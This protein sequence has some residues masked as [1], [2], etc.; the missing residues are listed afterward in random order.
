M[1][2]KLLPVPVAAMLLL[3]A[4]VT[5]NIYFPAA[6]AEKAADQIIKDIQSPAP[7]EAP[8][9]NNSRWQGNN[10][11]RWLDAALNLLVTPAHAGN[12]DLSLDS[13]EISRLR[14]AMKRR[15]ASL[16][17]YYAQGW[18]GI[19]ANGLLTV[20]NAAQV[21]LKDRNRLQKLVAAENRDRTQLYRAIANANGHP[22]WL[23]EIQATFAKRWVGN[24]RPGW[25]YQTADGS[26]RQK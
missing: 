18:I 19:Q 8:Q 2:Q 14:A 6:A 26:W 3:A 9:E 23:G 1:K 16:S 15:F 25:W 24:A 10:V 4:C 5:I 11:Y 13:P 22:D 7:P 17:P 12:A 21:P 20:R